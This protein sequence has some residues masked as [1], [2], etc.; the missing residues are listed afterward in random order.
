[1]LPALVR[2]RL[3]P[4][5][6]EV[7]RQHERDLARGLGRAVLPFALD[8]KYPNASTEWGWQFVF[9]AADLSRSAVGSTVPIPSARVGDPKGG[10][11][12]RAPGG[13]HEARQSARVS[14]RVGIVPTC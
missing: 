14:E 1:M 11:A 3:M 5:L 8:R 2:D 10:G 7:K 6:Q 12:G 4:H 13:D 9:P